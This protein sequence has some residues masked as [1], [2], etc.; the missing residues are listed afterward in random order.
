MDATIAKFEQI[1]KAEQLVRTNFTLATYGSDAVTRD[2]A[3]TI[4]LPKARAALNELLDG[5]TM[6]EVD[7]FGAYRKNALGR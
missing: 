6:D 5:L 7:A 1:L 2:R 4:N 3:N